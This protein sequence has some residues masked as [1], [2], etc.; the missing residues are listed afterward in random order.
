ML[1]RL[2]KSLKG[3]L[4]AAMS[5]FEAFMEAHG[6]HEVLTE[7]VEVEGDHLVV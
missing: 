3:V 4:E 1:V 6:V 7:V 5:F 2:A